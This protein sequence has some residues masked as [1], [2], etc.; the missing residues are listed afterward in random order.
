MVERRLIKDLEIGRA[1]LKTD[2]V[3]HALSSR[4]RRCA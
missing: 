2:T 3:R 1:T 4:T